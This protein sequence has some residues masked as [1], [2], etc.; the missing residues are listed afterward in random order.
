MSKH[1]KGPK[2]TSVPRG[3]K[4]KRFNDRFVPMRKQTHLHLGWPEGSKSSADFDFW[5]NYSF[6]LAMHDPK[7]RGMLQ[8][9]T[10]MLTSIS[11]IFQCHLEANRRQ[12]NL[13][14]DTSTLQ[15]LHMT[16]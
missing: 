8:T 5:V 12:C 3:L 15:S 13:F 1:L 16:G 10:E 9:E 6:K 11:D 2:I 14:T 7:E 4:L